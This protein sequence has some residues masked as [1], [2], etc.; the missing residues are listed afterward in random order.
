MA[1]FWAFT[2]PFLNFDFDPDPD[3]AFDFDV[4]PGPDPAADFD[5]DTKPKLKRL[6]HLGEGHI[7][8]RYMSKKS[9]NPSH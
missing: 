3:P 1:P 6:R 2:A 4:D 8:D 5:A 9:K 7:Q